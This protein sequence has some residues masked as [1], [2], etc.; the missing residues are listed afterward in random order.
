MS[1]DIEELWRADFLTTSLLDTRDGTPHNML[2]WFFPKKL[3]PRIQVGNPGALVILAR[4]GMVWT[5]WPTDILDVF[6]LI[7]FQGIQK[8]CLFNK[9]MVSV[10]RLLQQEFSW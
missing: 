7:G 6:S 3:H 10:H 2:N 5:V 1:W 4:Y 8:L 9:K